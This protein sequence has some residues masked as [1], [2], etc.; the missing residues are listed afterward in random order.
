M[1]SV[2]YTAASAMIA[3]ERDLEVIANNLANASVS[4]YR[5]DSTFYEVWKRVGGAG[6]KITSRSAREEAINTEV[7]IPRLFTSNEQ[8]A[9]VQTEAPLDLAIEGDAW[10]VVQ[11]K[12]GERYTR[13][14][15]MRLLADGTLTAADGS[16]LLGDGGPIVLPQGKPEIGGDGRIQVEGAQV[17]TLR[18][19]R[20]ADGDLEKEGANL[21]RLRAGAVELPVEENVTVRQGAIEGSAVNPVEELI[22]LVTAQRAYEQNARVVSLVVNEIDRKAVNEIAQL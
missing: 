10:F 6:A 20:A 3:R 22:K 9:I 5:P 8:G 13:G 2:L 1:N 17:G 19:A 14:G 12:A 21:Y 4:G 16:P 7:Q 11:T 18:L 15:S